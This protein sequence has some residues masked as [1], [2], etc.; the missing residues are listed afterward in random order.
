MICI[1]PLSELNQTHIHIAGEKGANLGEVTTAGFPVPNGFVLTTDAYDLFVKKNDFYKLII[2][3]TRNATADNPQAGEAA[4]QRIKHL[5]LTAKVPPDITEALTIATNA[6]SDGAVAV[7]A[8]ATT[9]DLPGANVIGQE[10]SYRNVFGIDELLKAV[11]NCWASLW[12]PSAV[13]HRVKHKISQADAKLAVIIQKEIK[14]EISGI[15]F[16]LN[17]NNNDADEALI[18]SKQGLVNALWDEQTALDLFVVNK[19]SQQIIEK[20]LSEK[21]F[22]PSDTIANDKK[23]STLTTL[24]APSL[25][26]D[27]V[28]DV[29]TLV[30]KVEAHYEL[31]MKI[32]W[33]FQNNKFYLL[34]ARPITNNSASS[35]STTATAS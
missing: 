8:S 16:S 10:E 29:T 3:W 1:L 27:Q 7:R 34:Q 35:K 30:A 11:K 26:D 4:F 2:D 5:F 13:N 33:A 23:Q 12:T 20:Q 9:R 28:L 22:D 18:K 24:P 32:D 31:P 19:R 14:A 6:L 21:D 15:A 25:T 17:P